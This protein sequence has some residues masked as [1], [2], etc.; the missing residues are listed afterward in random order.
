[1]NQLAHGS[2]KDSQPEDA[3]ERFDAPAQAPWAGRANFRDRRSATITRRRAFE[4]QQFAEAIR[5]QLLAIAN[6]L[7]T[8]RANA[9]ITEICQ[10]IQRRSEKHDAPHD[11]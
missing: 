3:F 6:Q 5:A 11:R 10:M 1:M 2:G 8:R 4:F 9:R 7:V